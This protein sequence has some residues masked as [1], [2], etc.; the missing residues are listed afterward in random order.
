MKPSLEHYEVGLAGDADLQEREEFLAR[1]GLD[2]V[3]LEALRQ[4]LDEDTAYLGRLFE[5][6][7]KSVTVERSS[8]QADDREI[9]E[10]AKT[11]LKE[12][13]ITHP[14]GVLELVGMLRCREVAGVHDVVVLEEIFDA[15]HHE[16]VAVSHRSDLS[17]YDSTRSHQLAEALSQFAYVS[18][19]TLGG[20][21]ARPEDNYLADR[22]FYNFCLKQK[23]TEPATLDNHELELIDD[24]V[25][26]ERLANFDRDSLIPFEIEVGRLALFGAD[27]TVLYIADSN[28][29]NN[30]I[31]VFKDLVG[32]INYE[33]AGQYFA[34][35]VVAD[36]PYELEMEADGLVDVGEQIGRDTYRELF[37]EPELLRDYLYL[38]RANMRETLEHDF[39]FN[40]KALSI[41]EQVFFLK[42][43]QKTSVAEVDLFRAFIARYGVN[44]MRT[45]LSLEK[46]D[47]DLG[48]KIITFGQNEEEA[49]KV[50]SYYGELLN[51]ADQA[52]QKVRI[53]GLCEGEKCEELTLQVRENILK[54][55]QKD[56]ER[57]VTSSDTSEV[58]DLIKTYV[59]EA[60]VYVALVQEA[61]GG[62]IESV[63]AT[64]LSEDECGQML[65]LMQENYDRQYAEETDRAFKNAVR[66]S[67]VASFNNT[68]TVF[69]I[70]REDERIVSFNR[71][72]THTGTDGRTMSYFGSFNADPVYSGVG[73][74]ML[75]RTIGEQLQRCDVM[76]AHC[77]PLAAITKKYI[78]DG[79]V[80]KETET[81]AGK[82]SFE[83]W[84]T[85]DVE[86][87]LV[88]KQLTQEALVARADTPLGDDNIL[89][90][91]VEARDQ[92]HELDKDQGFL[93]TRYFT[94]AGVTYAVFE[95][96]PSTLW[97]ELTPPRQE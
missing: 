40:L 71:F 97:Q 7:R 6:A 88:S 54:R 23:F 87:K 77:D 83:I 75:E 13:A 84:R 58:E 95:I 74:V 59:A 38:Q 52:E 57:A 19:Q 68:S 37:V 4:L 61:G 47:K 48:D 66:S 45:F 39:G 1:F 24:T 76:M 16:F 32:Q 46:G 92:F 20:D 96:A 22:Y 94:Q 27:N 55:A 43:L 89:V 41:K 36:I 12:Y 18:E 93:L 67:L 80:A 53:S 14:S 26:L 73:S 91:T 81:V 21:H 78:E 31:G 64:E 90:R 42:H 86:E 30:H 65:A 34:R 50:F 29:S 69:R 11:L 5:N 35:R 85:R 25:G 33:V 15:I 56:L 79:F 82:F 70:L 51:L 17:D 62:K 44:G 72:D 63:R 9:I 2:Q 10:H 3:S 49:K 28:Y 60:K 8:D